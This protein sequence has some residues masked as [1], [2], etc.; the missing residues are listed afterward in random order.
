MTLTDAIRSKRIYGTNI[1]ASTGNNT[2]S[3]LDT[4]APD[5]ITVPKEIIKPKKNITISED[6]L[7][8]NNISFFESINRNIKF[9]TIDYII[10]PTL[11]QLTYSM[12]TINFIYNKRGFSIKTSL[13]DR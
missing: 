4:V 1:S 13:M 3:N 11:N 9:T 8:V 7:F 10:N 2:Q 12:A 6:I 5:Y